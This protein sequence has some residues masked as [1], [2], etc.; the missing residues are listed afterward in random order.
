MCLYGKVVKE[1]PPELILAIVTKI[2][3][4]FCKLGETRR[5]MAGNE[6]VLNNLVDIIVCKISANARVDTIW[7]VSILALNNENRLILLRRPNIIDSCG[8]RPQD[9]QKLDLRG[10]PQHLGRQRGP[11]PPRAPL[12]LPVSRSLSSHDR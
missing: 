2:L 6:N 12:R 8:D 11:Q 4:I 5:L 1:H 9:D 7:A 3:G 10:H